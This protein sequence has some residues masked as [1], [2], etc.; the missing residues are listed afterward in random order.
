MCPSATLPWWVVCRQPISSEPPYR[1]N[2][3][4]G[5]YIRV[6]FVF[7]SWLAKAG[8]LVYNA[9]VSAHPHAS[10]VDFNERP[11]ILFWE[12]TRSCA[13]ACRH[14]R[15]IAQP[16]AH[17]EELAHE[18]AMALADKIAALRPPMVVLTGGDPMMRRDIF[19]IIR[20]LAG[21]G[22]RVALSPAATPRLLNTDFA[23]LKEAGVVSMSLSLDG[24]TRETHDAFRRVPHTFERTLEAARKAK[25]AGFQLQINTTVAKSTLPEMDAFAELMR[26]LAPDVWSVFLLVPTGRATAED[27]PSADDIE[28]LWKKLLALRETMPF[29]IKTTEGHHYRRA[30][31]Q[32]AA[33][34]EAPAPRHTVP[35]RDGKGVVFISHVGE[36]Q[37][38]GFLPLT[39]GNVRTDD[40]ASIYRTHPI[41]VTLRDDDAL[42]GKCGKCEYR[43]ICGGSRSRAYG[44]CGD[45]MAAEPLCSYIPAALRGSS[46]PHHD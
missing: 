44:T 21:Q 5:C 10:A 14:C 20:R 3:G 43:R 28:A 38:S 1:R 9:R 17:P 41:F 35:T 26:T 32:A 23:A 36:I 42:G 2:A 15:A 19:D 25:A 30:M 37:P 7:R 29:A 8:G 46:A 34:G 16:K 33:R 45:M 4:R 24:A 12:V 39:A 13:L 6:L 40:L 22:I 27:L 31:M 11:F 18:E